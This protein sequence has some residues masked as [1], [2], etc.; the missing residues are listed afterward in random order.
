VAAGTNA[1]KAPNPAM[2]ACTRWSE[3]RRRTTGIGESPS[4]LRNYLLQQCNSSAIRSS[5]IKS[6]AM[7]SI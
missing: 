3:F 4:V 7:D 1:S 6:L 5:S 2:A